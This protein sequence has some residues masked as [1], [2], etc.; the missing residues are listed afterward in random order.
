MINSFSSFGV[1]KF[2]LEKYPEKSRPSLFFFLNKNSSS[3]R[4]R[5]ALL[6][7]CSTKGV[8]LFEDKSL[9]LTFFLTLIGDGLITDAMFDFGS[10]LSKNN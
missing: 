10:W 3:F 2:E 6:G 1:F 4:R 7:H 9:I 8:F 5:E